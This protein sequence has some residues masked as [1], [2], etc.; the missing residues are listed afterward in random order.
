MIE[1]YTASL[2]ASG[3]LDSASGVLEARLAKDPS[4]V[5]TLKML[6]SVYRKLGR[7]ADAL[8]V[9]QRV[10][11]L[12]PGDAYARFLVEVMAE[13]VPTPMPAGDEGLQPAPFV[14]IENFLPADYHATLLERV[15]AAPDDD[16]VPSLVGRNEYKPEVRQ[17]FSIGGMKQIKQEIWDFVQPRL[18]DACTRLHVPQFE[19]GNTEIRV[20]TY[21]QGG[22]F[23]VHRDDS[24]P[25]TANRQ[26][27]FVYFFHRVP[28]RYKGGELLM[29]DTSADSQRYAITNFTKITPTDNAVII[30]PSRFY[31]AVVPVECD[32][33]D[34][35]DHRFVINGHIR[36]K[37]AV[38][39]PDEQAVPAQA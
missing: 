23:D 27:S 21:R 20:R 37:T 4:N 30:F 10:V 26:V 29:I 6:G 25:E 33:P 12:A 32:S 2:Y 8:A 11:V 15:L 9:Y 18:A 34:P 16:V 17:S 36:K 24:I 35:G 13:Q 31:H 7:L 1:S 5:D 28:R 3:I 39:A 38:P 19:V 14:W 22:F